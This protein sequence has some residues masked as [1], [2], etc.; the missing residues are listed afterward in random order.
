M[1]WKR[2]RI[3]KKTRA[4]IAKQLGINLKVNLFQRLQEIEGRDME[5]DLLGKR[6][7]GRGMHETVTK[8][9]IQKYRNEEK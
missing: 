7:M 1:K 9:A 4:I 5:E 2:G 3:E 8:V 6:E